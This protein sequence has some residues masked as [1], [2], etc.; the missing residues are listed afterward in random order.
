VQR[1]AARPI[2]AQRTTCEEPKVDPYTPNPAEPARRGVA[3][4][5]L[6]GDRA[7]HERRQ[8]NDSH[9]KL[10]PNA[11]EE[12]ILESHPKSVRLRNKL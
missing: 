11:S 6:K 8:S 12:E 7:S 4:H 5:I 9:A 3:A 10:M 2:N 1:E